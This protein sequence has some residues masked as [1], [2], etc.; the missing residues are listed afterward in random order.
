MWFHSG[1]IWVLDSIW[2]K[3]WFGSGLVWFG[4]GF[5]SVRIVFDSDSVWACLDVD[6]NLVR[7]GLGL[8]LVDTNLRHSSFRHDQGNLTIMASLIWSL[9]RWTFGFGLF[10]FDFILSERWFNRFLTPRDVS[11]LALALISVSKWLLDVSFKASFLL[12]RYGF[13]LEIW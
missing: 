2:F 3:A 10:E 11:R 9:L 4:L 13:A 12:L 8:D 5:D 1:L 7:I 6:F